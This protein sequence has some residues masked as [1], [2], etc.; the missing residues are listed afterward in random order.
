MKKWIFTAI[1]AVLIIILFCFK[2]IW[3]GYIY[4]ALPLLSLLS[5]FW[6]AIFIYDYYKFYYLNFEKGFSYFKAE[7]INTRNITVQEFEENIDLF[8]REYKKSLRIYKLVDFFKI[9][10]SLTILIIT[11]ICIFK[12]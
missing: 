9:L 12:L 2:T 11:I 10:F 7:T 8:I 6:L 1:I 4:I 3:A 5:L